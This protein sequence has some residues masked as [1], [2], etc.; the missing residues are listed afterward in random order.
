[1]RIRDPRSGAQREGRELL[2]GS[3]PVEAEVKVPRGNRVRKVEFY[4]QDELIATRFAA[5]YLQRLTITEQDPEGFVRVVGELDDGMTA[6]DV[7]FINSPGSSER[8]E[9][10]LIQLYVVVTDRKGKPMRGLEK[11]QFQLS[12][13]GTDQELATF[14]DAA[15]L[16]LTVGLTID[17]SASMFIKLPEVQDAAAKYVRSL[18]KARDRAFVVGF[19]SEPRLARDTTADLSRVVEGLYR[20]QPDGQTAIWRAVVYSLVQLQGLTGKKALI[21]YSDGADD[22]PNFSYKTCLRFARR[23]GVPIY[24]IVAND[25]IYRTKG[26]GLTVHSFL[27]RLEGLSREVGGRVFVTRVSDDLS[28]I[29]RQIDEE[30]RSQYVLGYYAQSG[31]G[32]KWREIQVKVS[33]PG[34][35]A[36]TIAGFYQ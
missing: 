31:E 19:G 12:E 1:M 17:S 24:F 34:A 2:L 32:H 23:V 28:A 26:K 30:L 16:P 5:P 3:V 11:G 33:A 8:L 35:S 13:A 10:E 7:L 22:D 25:E 14:S 21:V 15:D 36:R 6:E 18:T 9:V 4:W 20:L 29:Y 27:G